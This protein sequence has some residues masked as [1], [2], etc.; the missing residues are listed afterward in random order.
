MQNILVVLTVGQKIRVASMCRSLAFVQE[1][2]V[3][4][5]SR[6]RGMGKTNSW[7]SSRRMLV[8]TSN[9]SAHKQAHINRRRPLLFHRI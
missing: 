7:D 2:F 4:F 8:D 1:L 3:F 6:W 5:G 9:G